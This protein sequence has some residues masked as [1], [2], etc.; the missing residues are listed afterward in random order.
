MPSIARRAGVELLTTD[1]S[2]TGAVPVSSTTVDDSS[3]TVPDDS[4]RT[5]LVSSCSITDP[6]VVNESR[7]TKVNAGIER[8]TRCDQGVSALEDRYGYQS[9]SLDRASSRSTSG[10]APALSSY[11]QAAMLPAQPTWFGL[12]AG[13]D[14][15]G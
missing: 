10:V 13:A 9:G 11:C 15:F 8:A 3:R 7:S 12:H 1:A 6:P 4:S 14:S 5:C 2:R